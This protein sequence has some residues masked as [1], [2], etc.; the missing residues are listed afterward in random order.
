MGRCFACDPDAGVYVPDEQ[1]GGHM[2]EL[3]PDVWEG[4]QEAVWPD[5]GL[6]IV[7]QSLEPA[8]FEERR[9]G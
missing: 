7:D 6:I 4:I 3:R 1:L 8:D 2:A 5:G 9:G